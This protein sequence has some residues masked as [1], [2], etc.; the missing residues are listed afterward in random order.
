MRLDSIYMFFPRNNF[1]PIVQAW[2]EELNNKFIYNYKLENST[3]SAQSINQFDVY[4]FDEYVKVYGS[5]TVEN[6]DVN[7]TAKYWGGDRLGTSISWDGYPIRQSQ[8]FFI[9]NKW[10]STYR[11]RIFAWL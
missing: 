5:I 11:I 8:W 10:P 2:V 3:Q 9:Y 7:T 1:I 6:S 4:G